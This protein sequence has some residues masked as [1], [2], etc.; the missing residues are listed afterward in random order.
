MIAVSCP[1]QRR[2]R[3]L[4]KTKSNRSLKSSSSVRKKNSNKLSTY[5]STDGLSEIGASES[6]ELNVNPNIKLRHS[7]SFHQQHFLEADLNSNSSSMKRTKSC[8][9]IPISRQSNN[10]NGMKDQEERRERRKGRKGVTCRSFHQQKPSRSMNCLEADLLK[11][12]KSC[13]QI[14][15]SRQLNNGIKDQEERRD[16]TSIRR[17][18]FSSTR[19]RSIKLAKSIKRSESKRFESKKTKDQSKVIRTSPGERKINVKSKSSKNLLTST[20]SRIK[21][22]FIKK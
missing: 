22:S 19:N 13:N 4:Q 7:R 21:K 15:I 6:N 18:G 2:G 12:T 9:Q 16:K 11:R 17:K 14:P 3:G 5:P 1:A 8:N 10:G 20:L